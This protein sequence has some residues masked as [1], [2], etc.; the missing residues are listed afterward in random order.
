MYACMY[1]HIYCLC[2][3][4]YLQNKT[5]KQ[6][7]QSK[8]SLVELSGLKKKFTLMVMKMIMVGWYG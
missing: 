8:V 3:P 4:W 2:T 1:M 7:E 6:Q 5:T